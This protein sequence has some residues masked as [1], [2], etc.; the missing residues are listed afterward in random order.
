MNAN[1]NMDIQI[2]EDEL[3]GQLEFMDWKMYYYRVL[4]N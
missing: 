2:Q 3:G 4:V 1:Y